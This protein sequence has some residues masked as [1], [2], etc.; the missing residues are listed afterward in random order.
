MSAAQT[1]AARIDA[2][3]AAVR[4]ALG[5][6]MA[7]GPPRIGLVLGSGLGG[8]SAV[9]EAAGRMPSDRIPG[10]PVSTVPGHAGELVFGRLGG[11]PVA[12]LN[13]RV[14]AY[15]G[16]DPSALCLP[17][18]TLRALG[19]ESVILVSTVGSLNPEIRPG[20]L[21]A[22]SDHLNLTGVN[23]LIGANDQAIGPRFPPMN[24]AYDMALRRRARRAAERLNLTM[25]EGV[26][27]HCSG[28]S[29]ETPAEI[30]AFRMLG[31]D[32]VGMSMV[33]ETIIARHC[34]LSV[35]GIAAIT[36]QAA[37]LAAQAPSHEETLSGAKLLAADLARLLRALLE[38]WD[39]AE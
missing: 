2:A 33:P 28:P 20:Q 4:A 5:A 8:A 39:D 29:F 35:L 30:R 34:G 38:H 13:G 1:E 9:I 23:P 15:E 25:P 17:I 16:F 19:C 32:L 6:A 21:V 22:V 3:V 26:M 37:G 31:G 12:C 7:G 27:V 10:F 14:H 11:K 18:R 24:G 36:N